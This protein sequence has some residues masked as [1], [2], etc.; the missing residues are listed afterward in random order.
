MSETKV[1]EVDTGCW[2]RTLKECAFVFVVYV[3]VLG[4][5]Q[6]SSPYLPDCDSYFHSGM[7]SRIGEA[8]PVRQFPWNYLSMWSETW[9]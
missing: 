9:Q 1:P 4:L 2:R 7:A 5:I 3:M 8:G 6:F